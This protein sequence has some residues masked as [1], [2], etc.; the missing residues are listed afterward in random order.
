MRT[1]DYW[2]ASAKAIMTTDTFPEGRD[3]EG[4]ARQGDGDD[5]RHGQGRR[6]D[7]A[8]HGDHAR[9]SC[10]P[11]RR[12]SAAALQGLLRAG[13]ED[14]FNAVTVDGDTSTSDTLLAF[15]TGAAAAKGAPR[16]SRAGDPRLKAF[17]KAFHGVLADLAEQVARD[18]EGARKLVEVIVEGAKSRTLRREKSRAPSPIRRWSRPPSPARTP[19]GAAS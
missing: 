8:G 19:T 11:T 13:V 18:G 16:I 4:E 1:G 6:H 2:L 9:R 15:A 14:T 5:Q 3:R 7:R 10:S 12:F 17:A